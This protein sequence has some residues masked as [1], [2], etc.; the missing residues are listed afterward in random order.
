MDVFAE[1]VELDVEA[2]A[3]GHGFEV[4]HLDGVGDDPAGDGVGS[5]F[6]GGEGD[7]VEADGAFWDNEAAVFGGEGD[8]ELVVLAVA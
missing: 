6:G 5:D 3:W 1:H 2:A 8:S 4:G 7:A